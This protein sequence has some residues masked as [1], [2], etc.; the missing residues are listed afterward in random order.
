[1]TKAKIEAW[2]D[3]KQLIDVEKGEHKFSIWWE[4]EPVRP[5]GIATW[6]TKGAVRAIRLRLLG[7]DAK[8][9]NPPDK[10]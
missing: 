7:S 1:V 3:D 8:P 10:Q 9:A 2:V 5:L 4:Q 6:N